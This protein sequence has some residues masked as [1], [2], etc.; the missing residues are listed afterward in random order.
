MERQHVFSNRRKLSMGIS[1]DHIRKR[2]AAYQ[3]CERGDHTLNPDLLPAPPYRAASVLIPLLARDGGYSVLLTQRTAHLQVHPGQVSFPGGGADHGDAHAVA[4]ALREAEEE[5]GLA[6][7]NV[8]VLG[9]LDHYITRTG[10]R[11]TPVVGLVE[12]PPQWRPDS[13]EVEVIFEVPLAYVLTPGMLARRTL[14]HE[15][16]ERHFYGMTWQDF[17]VWG[18]TAGMLKNFV[19]VISDDV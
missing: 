5:I 8:S 6:P 18:A 17:H 11:V 1:L 16:T 19:D 9:T 15:G 4:T 12:P 13:F 7:E 10:Y 3:P 2:L 14:T